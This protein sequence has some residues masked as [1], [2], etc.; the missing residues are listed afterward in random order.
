MRRVALLTMSL[1]MGCATAPVAPTV[2]TPTTPTSVVDPDFVAGYTATYRFRLGAPRSLTVTPGG[3]SVLFLRSGPRSFVHDLW[4]LDPATG[5]EAVFLTAA[6]MLAG[7]AETLTAEEKA[8]RERMRQTS[9]SI[10]S[11]EV[12]AEGKRL[13]VPLSGRLFVVD[14]ATR[15]VCTLKSEAKTSAESAGPH[16]ATATGRLPKPRRPPRVPRPGRIAPHSPQ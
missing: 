16:L 14:R 9:R 3:D 4:R 2:T 13:L 10:A 11:Y 7:Q 15:S 6:D 8:R 1:V 12:P 5:A